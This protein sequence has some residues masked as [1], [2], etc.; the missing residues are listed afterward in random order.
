[1]AQMQPRSGSQSSGS[2]HQVG[3]IPIIALG[4]GL[5]IFFVMSFVICI[6]GY[7]V[8]PGFSVQH[9]ALS[10]FLPGFELLSWRSFFLGLAE[11]FVWGWYIAFVFGSLYNFF[12][13]RLS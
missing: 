11:S 1:M 13:R 9:G 6:V 7:L 8:L 10:I 4:L 3:A 2:F 5:S 12:V